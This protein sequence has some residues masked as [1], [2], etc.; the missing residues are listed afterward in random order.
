MI[1]NKYLWI[2]AFIL[3]SQIDISK[4]NAEV[5]G[6][7]R[8]GSFIISNISAKHN[9]EISGDNLMGAKLMDNA[10]VEESNISLN[11]TGHLN[12]W[13]EWL[14]SK[15]K[16][17]YYM[18]MNLYSGKYLTTKAGNEK[19]GLSIVQY[20][21]TFDDAQYWVIKQVSSNKYQI[22][23]KKTLRL[24]SHNHLNGLP[25]S[26]NNTNDDTQ[27]WKITSIAADS[28]RD[29]DV[30]RFFQRTDGS[31]AFDEGSSIPLYSN[32]NRGK[33]LWVTGDTFYNQV[34]SK[35]EFACNLI[36]PYHNSVLLQPADHSWDP[37]KTKNLISKD[38]AQVF[39]PSNPKD[40]FWPGAG[41]EIGD[42]IYVHN[43]EVIAGTL[44]T[45]NQYLGVITESRDYNINPVKMVS[46]QGMSGQTGIVYTIGMVKPVG[47]YIYAYGLGGA[48]GASIYVARFK[49]ESPTVWTFWNGKTWAA[50]PSTAAAAAVAKGPV[51]NNGVGYINGK[52]VL[53]TMDFGFTCDG[54]GKN[55][56]SSISDSPVGPFVHK[57]LIYSVPDYKQGH[58]PVFYNPT[59]HAE[60]DNGHHELLIAYCLNFYNKNDKNNNTCLTPC[61]NSDGSM[62]PN[63]YRIKGIRVP[64]S[65]IGL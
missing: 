36:F 6:I 13:Q 7:G 24:L 31:D 58:S 11:N 38:G 33:V 61:S 42:K 10:S 63:D 46:V 55:M 3:L 15:Q 8:Y 23:N 65:L 49:P 45:V 53:I 54:P 51:N 9:L 43:I 4:C 32:I 20:H 56:Y 59:V 29:D 21:K 19:S 57:K 37:S 14:I 2:V 22:I 17:G 5:T 60:F 30:V 18:I 48:M 35:G 25:A 1:N 27:L 52:Y 26:N 40:L 62:D 28:Y 12:R 50:K 34:D 44:T 64:Y 47:H 16:N 41:V 39:N